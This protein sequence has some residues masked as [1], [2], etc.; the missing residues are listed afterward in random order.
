MLNSILLRIRKLYI[1]ITAPIR[2]KKLKSEDFTVISNNCW[3]GLLYESYGIEKKSPTVGMYF[4]AEEYLKFLKNLKYYTSCPITFVEPGQARHKDYYGLDSRFGTYPIARLDDVEIAMLHY[5]SEAE[6]AEKWERRCKRIN[7]DRLL[8]KM[9]DQNQCPPEYADA[10]SQLPF[11]NKLFFSCQ[12]WPGCVQLPG[13]D[14]VGMLAE[15]FGASKK[16][17]VNSLIND[18]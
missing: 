12:S 6:A 13:K 17:N 5:R 1:R 10:F 15:P 14:T 7:W 16:L 8:V 18:L 3:A 4:M 11:K 9:N 2:R